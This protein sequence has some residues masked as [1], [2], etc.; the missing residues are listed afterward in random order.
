MGRWPGEEVAR[1]CWGRGTSMKKKDRK[2]AITA[3]LVR[4]E[5]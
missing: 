2:K 5:N 1:K 4:T 3:Y